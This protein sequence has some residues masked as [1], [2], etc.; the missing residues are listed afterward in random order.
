MLILLVFLEL[1]FLSLSL[2]SFSFG[3]LSLQRSPAQDTRRQPALY[4]EQHVYDE[5]EDCENQKIK[6]VM[7]SSQFVP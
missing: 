1:Y 7:S 4:Y 3:S 5:Q 6:I 2:Y